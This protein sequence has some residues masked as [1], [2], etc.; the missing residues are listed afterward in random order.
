VIALILEDIR[1]WRISQMSRTITLSCLV[2]LAVGAASLLQPVLMIAASTLVSILL[3][4][5]R[6]S[7]YY[8]SSSARKPLITCP[9][10]PR[11]AAAAKAASSI[12]IWL[13]PL[14][15]LSPPLALTVAARGLRVDAL[16]ACASS[17]L[18]AY[19]VAVGLSFIVS[20]GFGRSDGLIGLFLILC[21]Q[22]ATALVP[23]LAKANP[24]V[25]AWDFLKGSATAGDWYW[26]GISAALAAAL[27]GGAALTLAHIRKGYRA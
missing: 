4:W 1:E 10:S 26:M 23:A 25:Q 13:L 20:L 11:G 22:G 17:W 24:F 5:S 21:W 3:G 19:C 16:A 9:V 8:I 15:A 2:V 27:F 18:V 12:A 14:L 7:Q 6:G